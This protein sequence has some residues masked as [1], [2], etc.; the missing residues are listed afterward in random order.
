MLGK[1]LELQMRGNHHRH[2][3]AVWRFAYYERDLSAWWKRPEALRVDCRLVDEEVRLA[4]VRGDETCNISPHRPT[5][6]YIPRIP[7]FH[8][9]APIARMHH[10]VKAVVSSVLVN[11]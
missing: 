11:E 1:E 5:S 7:R 2:L 10:K 3:P 9:N 6:Q 8:G 4:L